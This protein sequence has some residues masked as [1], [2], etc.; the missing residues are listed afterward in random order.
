MTAFRSRST[1]RGAAA[2]AGETDN[3]VLKAARLLAAEAGVAAN[4]A[5]RLT[6]RIPGRGR[7]GRRLRRCRRGVARALPPVADRARIRAAAGTCP[8]HRRGRADVPGEQA[9]ARDRHR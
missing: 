5:L 1:G 2:I 6:K 8:V 9:R 4:A 3:L 7:P